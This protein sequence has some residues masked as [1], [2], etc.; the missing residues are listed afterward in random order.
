M[1]SPSFLPPS[2]LSSFLPSLSLSLPPSLLPPLSPPSPFP[3]L[4]L[5]LALCVFITAVPITKLFTW[6]EGDRGGHVLRDDDLPSPSPLPPS[7]LRPNLSTKRRKRGKGGKSNIELAALSLSR[8]LPSFLPQGSKSKPRATAYAGARAP[9][10]G[11]TRQGVVLT[12][13]QSLFDCQ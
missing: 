4:L 8:A 9:S 11:V 10:G 3:L 1:A 12:D 6:G 7:P 13:L 5:S 2:L